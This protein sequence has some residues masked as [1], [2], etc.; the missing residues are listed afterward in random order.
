MALIVRDKPMGVDY[1]IHK[2]QSWIYSQLLTVWGNV[3]YDAYPRCYRNKKANGFIAELFK[4]G[5]EYK[6]VYWDD[7]VA[8]MS[9]FG[10][11]DSEKVGVLHSVDVHLV[12][13]TN[14]KKLKPSAVFRADNEVRTDV[15]NACSDTGFGFR[16]TS[17][18][19]G[20]ENVLKEYP[21]S[22]REKR[23]DTVDMHPLHCFRLNFSLQYNPNKIC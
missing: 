16:L 14:L 12:F 7:A 2:L 4:G 11:D 3:R 20:L 8:A 19:T 13:F 18:Q 21:S 5:K 22:I 17:I 6:E 15:I 1:H 10:I 9:F 23:L